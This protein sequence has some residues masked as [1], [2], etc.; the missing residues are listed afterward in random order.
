MEHF[1]GHSADSLFDMVRYDN[2][3]VFIRLAAN[4][5]VLADFLSNMSPEMRKELLTRFITGVESDVNT[6][7]ERAMDIADC[8][9]A[10]RTSTDISGL[11]QT[12]LQSNLNRCIS[13]QQYLGM[14]L[15]SI[16]LQVF[17]LV[18][19][20]GALNKLWTTLGNYEILKRSALENKQ[21]EIVEIVL[22]Y[23]DEDGVASFKNFL[24][25]YGDSSKW[26]VS[27][28]ENWVSIR[29]LSDQP[30]IIYANMPLD[31]TQEM[32]ARAQDSLFIFL[33]QQS[34]QP[35]VLVHR[36][37]SYHLDKTL[38]RLKPSVKLAI[39][40]SCGSYNKG[41]SIAT[42]NPDVQVIGSKKTGAKSVNDP[43]LDVINETLV[44][45]NDLYWPE[46]WKR[47][48]ARFT[49]DETALSLFN[50]YFPPSNNVS[51]FV[52]KLFNY[53]NRFV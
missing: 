28:N 16:L 15:Y 2:F 24:K 3:H 40:G 21:G 23:G 39:L 7:L 47:L 6:G 26:N 43:I 49:K 8:F 11:I 48:A 12:E 50:E 34:L 53:Y 38:K 52:L 46:I 1:K 19:Q 41:I 33:E 20:G 37:H 36:G 31:I 14:R 5:N 4:Y 17:D 35:A 45:K 44:S 10:L 22:F 29:S 18:K 51:L 32:D 27:R 30:L 9:A 42:I 25:L 13:G